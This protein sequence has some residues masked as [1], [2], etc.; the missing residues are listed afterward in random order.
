M[1]DFLL[2]LKFFGGIIFLFA[3]GGMIGHLLKIDKYLENKQHE[4][5]EDDQIENK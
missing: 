4:Y 3:I 2:I 5:N 1:A